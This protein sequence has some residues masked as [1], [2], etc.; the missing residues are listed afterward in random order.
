MLLKFMS[1]NLEGCTLW[2]LSS[3]STGQT[4]HHRKL[5]LQVLVVILLMEDVLL[6]LLFTLFF[7]ETGT[8]FCCLNIFY[9]A[10]LYLRGRTDSGLSLK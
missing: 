4:F 5:R 8:F 1:E 3:L 10:A 2:C 7:N 6:F 9:N